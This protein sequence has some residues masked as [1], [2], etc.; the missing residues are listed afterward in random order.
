[1]SD[2]VCSVIDSR[3][4]AI[5]GI[6][7]KEERRLIAQGLSAFNDAGLIESSILRLD[8]GVSLLVKL[9]AIDRI[10]TEVDNDMIERKQ[11]NC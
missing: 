11:I 9:L 6:S 3:E 4:L 10:N 7:G 8:D 2:D 5:L 1:M